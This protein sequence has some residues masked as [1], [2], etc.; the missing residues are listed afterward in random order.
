MKIHQ[1]LQDLAWTQNLFLQD[2]RR[3][4]IFDKLDP[5]FEKEDHELAATMGDLTLVLPIWI[6]H[7]KQTLKKKRKEKLKK[8]LRHIL[9]SQTASNSVTTN[10]S[11]A[12][13]AKTNA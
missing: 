7:L 4:E 2:E 13:W 8:T 6:G 9:S 10:Q 1:F 11:Q 5:Y 12:F 3:Q